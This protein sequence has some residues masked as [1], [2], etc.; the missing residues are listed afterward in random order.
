MSW[1]LTATGAKLDLRWLDADSISL[2]DIAHHLAQLNRYTGACCRPYSV[3]EHSLLVVQLLEHD[4]ETQPALLQA[5]LMHDAHE[6]YTADLSSPMKQVVG[7]AWDIEETRIQRAVLQ[8]FGLADAYCRYANVIKHADLLALSTER[9][10]LLPPGGPQW[11]VQHTHPPAR[12]VDLHSRAG[13]DWADWRA[14]FIDK[15]A[16]LTEQR[17]A[18]GE[19]LPWA[20]EVAA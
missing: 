5:A 4:G 18:R 11:P 15:F 1:M 14:A 8:R 7:P 20:Q 17:R 3:A 16:E 6:A 9:A 13:L 2:L 12:W 19:R 10:A